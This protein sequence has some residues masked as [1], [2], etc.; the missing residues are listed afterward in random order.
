MNE[1]MGKPDNSMQIIVFM[2]WRGFRLA[3]RSL[4]LTVHSSSSHYELLLSS[5]AII[6]NRTKL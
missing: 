5:H 3:Q 6:H 4:G 1:L 2:L